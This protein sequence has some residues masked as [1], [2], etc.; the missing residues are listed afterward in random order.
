MSITLAEIASARQTLLAI[1]STNAATLNS[2]DFATLKSTL[3]GWAGA[4]YTESFLAYSFPIQLPPAQFQELYDC[5]DGTP[6]D[7]WE[8]I[9]FF[10]G[11]TIPEY[12]AN[13]QANIQGITLTYSLTNTT[14][15]EF[16]TPNAPYIFN[17]HVTRT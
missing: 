4:G 15:T 1:E 7:I 13:Y 14:G 17:I 11:K 12:I 9:A 3:Y 2:M 5:S 10:L 16:G 8:Y 6:R